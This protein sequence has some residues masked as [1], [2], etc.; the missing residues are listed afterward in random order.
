MH[1]MCWCAFGAKLNHRQSFPAP[2]SAE[3][4]WLDASVDI[5]LCLSTLRSPSV[6][7]LFF[8]LHKTGHCFRAEL[9]NMNMQNPHRTCYL[10][11]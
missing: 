8:S 9:L 6:Q 10:K 3:C 2:S 11:Q 7:A 4:C 1:M 5:V